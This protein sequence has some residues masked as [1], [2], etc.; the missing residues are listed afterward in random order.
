MARCSSAYFD[1]G[2]CG[3]SNSDD[4]FD[5]KK[6]RLAQDF[7]ETASVKK[8]LETVPV[9]QFN[10]DFFRTHPDPEYRLD[11]VGLLDPKDEREIYL[12]TPAL[13]AELADE[14]DPCSLFTAVNRRGVVALD[15]RQA[16]SR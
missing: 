13:S 9:G 4:P 6:L 1:L 2:G 8:L 3:V 5:P 7:T 11:S 10:Q 12:V 16:S 15:S 14:F